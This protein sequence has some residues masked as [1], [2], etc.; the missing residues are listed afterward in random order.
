MPNQVRGLVISKGCLIL[1]EGLVLVLPK[2][3]SKPITVQY[4]EIENLVTQTE[5]LVDVNLRG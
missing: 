3:Y 4:G 2:R 5:N 1:G